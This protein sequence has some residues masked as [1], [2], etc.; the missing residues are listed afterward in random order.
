MKKSVDN[1]HKKN[2]ESYETYY[3]G[4]FVHEEKNSVSNLS[5]IST[6]EGRLV[7]KGTDAAPDF[8]W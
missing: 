6:P 7:N 3:C 8:V 4:M 2:G 5:F 1:N